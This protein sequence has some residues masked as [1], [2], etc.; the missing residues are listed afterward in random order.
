MIIL[1][2]NDIIID[3][4]IIIIT[5]AI[6]VRGKNHLVKETVQIVAVDTAI[7]DREMMLPKE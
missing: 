3:P 2:V 4:H 1:Q 5:K 7:Q 6:V